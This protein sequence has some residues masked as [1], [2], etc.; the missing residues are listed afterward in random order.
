MAERKDGGGR[1]RVSILCDSSEYTDLKTKQKTK[2]Y[3]FSNL[4]VNSL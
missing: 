3:Y 4:N 2:N 1:S